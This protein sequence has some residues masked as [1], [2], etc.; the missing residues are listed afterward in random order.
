MVEL[1]KNEEIKMI[2][3][4]RRLY[5]PHF[6]MSTL[7]LLTNVWEE[8][9]QKLF[10]L[11]G[12]QLILNKKFVYE[13][14]QDQLMDRMDDFLLTNSNPE[15]KIHGGYE[16]RTLFY[17]AIDSL[18]RGI[19][20]NLSY[21]MYPEWLVKNVYEEDTVEAF[22]LKIK[23]GCKI[24]RVLQKIAVAIG[25]EQEYEDFRLGH[26]QVL[27][28]KKVTGD[29]CIS[30][31]PL[32]FITMSDNDCGWDSCMSWDEDGCY[33]RGTV[34]MMNSPCVVVA[35]LKD[36]NDMEIDGYPWSNK[37]WRQLFVVIEDVIAGIKSYPY[38]NDELSKEVASWLRELATQNLGW[39]YEQPTAIN[40]NTSENN[41]LAADGK[42]HFKY[43]FSADAM[44][45]DFGCAPH[46][47]ICAGKDVD[48]AGTLY[49]RYSGPSQCM[50]C[51]DIDANYGDCG[52]LVCDDCEGRFTCSECGESFTGEESY[53]FNDYT[54]CS[55][56]YHNCIA[57]CAIT[58]ERLF[59]DEMTSVVVLPRLNN[60]EMAVLKEKFKRGYWG[61][62]CDLENPDL[63]VQYCESHEN[64][65]FFNS[66]YTFEEFAEACLKKDAQYQ[67]GITPKAY[68]W[69]SDREGA[70]FIYYDQLT[71]DAQDFLRFESFGS[72][73][74]M[75]EQWIPFRLYK[76]TDKEHI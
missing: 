54:M 60:E 19:R 65:I 25:A 10:T 32:D 28:Q 67:L 13:E 37:K 49:V 8:E 27:N 26:S 16:F 18:N 7:D 46:H 33:K 47:I 48:A 57:E 5:A 34:E 31:H 11:F 74:E 73:R 17:R 53:I 56:C 68:G 72:Y 70:H 76:V 15:E 75:M 64:T 42:S 9:K 30:I 1:I 23:K 61:N 69:L 3:A 66:D 20:D 24:S 55:D 12:N 43:R 22:G 29:L 58:G 4:R 35:Y 45:N 21:M 50:N 39:K 71:E 44:Y 59:K 36:K 40:Y 6:E 63:I 14:S 51:G 62:I 38:Y 52:Y 41:F 2:N